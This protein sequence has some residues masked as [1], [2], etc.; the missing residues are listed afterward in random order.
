[1]KLQVHVLHVKL[2]VHFPEQRHIISTQTR[3]GSARTRRSPV[4]T[5]SASTTVTGSP[6]QFGQTVISAF[7]ATQILQLYSI[8]TQSSS[9][10][11]TSRTKRFTAGQD[12]VTVTL[13]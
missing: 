4:G 5:R 10:P 13:F 6:A 9:G 3:T 1:M 12:C 7:S 2:S 8:R 11:V